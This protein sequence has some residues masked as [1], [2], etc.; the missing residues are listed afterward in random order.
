MYV[1]VEENPNCSSEERML[2]QSGPSRVVSHLRLPG[3]DGVVEW[4]QVTA[5]EE[6]ERFGT[7][8]AVEIED[9]GAGNAWLIYGGLWGIRF[10]LENSSSP[11]SLSDK[12]QWGTPFKVLD[13]SGEDIRFES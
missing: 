11:W 2:S 1:L 3:P 9:S 12:S 8:Q 4:W 13:I 6:G 5:V 10:R 7:A